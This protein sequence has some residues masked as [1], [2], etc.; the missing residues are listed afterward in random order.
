MTEPNLR[1]FISAKNEYG[2]KVGDSEWMNWS[3]P[4][5][6]KEPFDDPDSLSVGDMVALVV[7]GKFISSVQRVGDSLPQNGAEPQAMPAGSRDQAIGRQV[8]LKCATE[9]ALIAEFPSKKP[10]D[11]AAT[12]AEMARILGLTLE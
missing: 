4:E 5:Y 1:G 11:V 7:N 12:V 9:L 2:I 8:A 6:R 3:K 10:E